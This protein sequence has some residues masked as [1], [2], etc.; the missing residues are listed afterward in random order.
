MTGI[1]LLALF[2]LIFAT[3]LVSGRDFTDDR[4]ATSAGKDLNLLI[5]PAGI[6]FSGHVISIAHEAASPVPNPAATTI[7]FLV[8]DAIRGTRPH[9]RLM[10]REWAG[11]WTRGER[12]RVGERVM[13]FL[14][15][16]GKLGFTS[17][18]AGGIGRFALDP[19]ERIVLNPLQV[20]IFDQ[21]WIVRGRGIIP[22]A[23][24]VPALQRLIFGNL[25]NAGAGRP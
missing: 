1:R 11:L 7:T 2:T 9:E 24:F 25:D 13:L 16:P 19:K 5:H 14:Y 4:M 15:P 3:T 17:P 8:D 12:Y 6:I 22:Y 18:V 20:R 10:I 23:E 21:D